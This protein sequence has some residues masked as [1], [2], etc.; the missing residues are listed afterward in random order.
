MNDRAERLAAV[1]VLVVDDDADQ[2]DIVRRLF[3]RAGLADVSTADHAALALDVARSAQPDLI[4]LDLAMPGRSG[5][6]LLPEL[7]VASPLSSIVILSNLPRARL[8]DKL[9]ERGAV[10][11]VEKRTPAAELVAA[12]LSTAALMATVRAELSLGEPLLASP[13]VARRFVREMLTPD[14][15]ALV[16]DVELLVSELVTNAVVHASDSPR[17]HVIVGPSI[18]R[19]A[20]Y[21]TDPAMPTQREPD[22]ARPGGRGLNLVET[23]ASRWGADR[24]DAGKVVWF[25]I[26]R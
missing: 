8:A 6:D 21:D 7:H 17:I 22:R 5:W 20:V 23:V 19:V 2:L 3:E 4:V 18:V 14:A 1:R 11:F 16:G 25:E 12:L 24:V 26:D 10:G 15:A 13:K 9:Q